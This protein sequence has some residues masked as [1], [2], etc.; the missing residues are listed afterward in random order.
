MWVENS[1]PRV[2]RLLA[3]IDTDRPREQLHNLYLNGTETL[4]SDVPAVPDRVLPD[5][6]EGG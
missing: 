4:R 2:V 3:H 6:A 5:P 1:M